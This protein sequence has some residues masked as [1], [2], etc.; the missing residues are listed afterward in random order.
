[1]SAPPA[2]APT[3]DRGTTPGADDATIVVGDEPPGEAALTLGPGS[4]LGEYELVALLGAGGCGSVYEAR[5]RPRGDRVAIKVLHEHV[6]ESREM[7]ERFLREAQAVHR[8]RH[9]NI[10]AIHEVGGLP[11]ARP[12]LVME[13]LEGHSLGALLARGALSPAEALEIL[14]PVCAAVDA[15]HRACIVHRDL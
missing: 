8:I 15:A 2:H 13:L 4:V 9:P 1:M 5:R 7:V 14:E 11:S 6:A 10:V 12:Y 3:T